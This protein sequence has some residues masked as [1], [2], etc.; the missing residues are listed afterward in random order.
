MSQ[1]FTDQ[2]FQEEVIEASRQKPVLVDF[3]A[4]W[5]GPCQIQGPIIDELAEEMQGK[6]AIGKMDTEEAKDISLRYQV[7]SIPTIL[8]FRNGEIKES[9]VGLQPKEALKESLEKYL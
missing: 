6:A 4:S 2:N 1:N 8:I 7:M 9:L 3:Y 5:C